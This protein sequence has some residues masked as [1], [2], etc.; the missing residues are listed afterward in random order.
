VTTAHAQI[1][2][3]TGYTKVCPICVK[4]YACDSSLIG[5]SRDVMIEMDVICAVK[6]KAAK[7]N[8]GKILKLIN[9]NPGDEE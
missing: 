2:I 6:V 9:P 8:G 5:R 4:R 3:D 1:A 7:A